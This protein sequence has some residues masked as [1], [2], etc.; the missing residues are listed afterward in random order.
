MVLCFLSCSPQ[1]KPSDSA[2]QS[3]I[4]SHRGFARVLSS[5]ALDSENLSEVYDAVSESSLNGYDEEYMLSDL[6]ASPGSG[7]GASST[8]AAR[9]SYSRPLRNVLQEYLEQQ[10]STKAGGTMTVQRYLDL[11]SDSKMQIYWPYSEECFDI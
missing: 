5:L 1:G 7:V 11:L 9:K 2:S 6:I 10:L 4:L 3:D 8:K